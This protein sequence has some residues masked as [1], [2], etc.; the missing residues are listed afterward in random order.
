[1]EAGKSGKVRVRSLR[2]SGLGSA[3]TRVVGDTASSMAGW[4]ALSDVRGTSGVTLPLRVEVRDAGSRRVVVC[5]SDEVRAML[6][7]L[8][9]AASSARPS[10]KDT[11]RLTLR[12]CST[13]FLTDVWYEAR[14]RRLG[15]G[16][17]AGFSGAGSDWRLRA[18]ADEVR[19]LLRES[20]RV[21][22]S[23]RSRCESIEATGG[24]KRRGE[25]GS[26]CWD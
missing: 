20:G 19:T 4:R 1:M 10:G 3:A 26:W 5:L 25:S 8:A 17:E 6:E 9:W 15:R 2:P 23:R 11:G 14:G 12:S 18:A 13:M 24:A 16:G 21:L 7:S 22:G